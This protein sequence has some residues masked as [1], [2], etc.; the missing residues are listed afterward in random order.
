MKCKA[1]R[2]LVRLSLCQ[3]SFAHIFNPT[4]LG[5]YT[6]EFDQVSLYKT[7][8]GCQDYLLAYLA[9]DLVSSGCT[10]VP[11]ALCVLAKFSLAQRKERNA[12]SRQFAFTSNID[13]A[14][15][16]MVQGCPAHNA[17]SRFQ[18]GHAPALPSSLHKP[19]RSTCHG[20]SLLCHSL[21]AAD[22]MQVL[23]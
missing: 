12:W 2:S 7:L 1:R 4:V 10:S 14:S 13:I 9:F 17:S 16:C 23:R 5:S 22:K 21:A 15:F 20:T 18:V 8:C 6:S 11:W 19:P 3:I